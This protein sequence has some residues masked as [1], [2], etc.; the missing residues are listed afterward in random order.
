M[1][2]SNNYK[3]AASAASAA[4]TTASATVSAMSGTRTVLR[5]KPS[6][7]SSYRTR[8]QKSTLS[9]SSLILTL[10][11]FTM[12]LLSAFATTAAAAPTISRSEDDSNS[13]SI[14]GCPSPQACEAHCETMMNSKGYC[15]EYPRRSCFCT[16]SSV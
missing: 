16:L 6:S 14:Y 9:K 4:S 3:F 12:V 8:Y 11:I 13:A 7:P 2:K 15:G 5:S 1:C 10:V